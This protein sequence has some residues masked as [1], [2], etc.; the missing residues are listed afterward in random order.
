MVLA[1]DSWEVGVGIH[2]RE[3]RGRVDGMTIFLAPFAYRIGWIGIVG[4]T[5]PA[6][7]NRV[8]SILVEMQR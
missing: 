7:E 1:K 8:P 2:W 6:T 4:G 3:Y 5:V